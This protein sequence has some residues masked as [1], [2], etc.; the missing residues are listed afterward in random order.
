MRRPRSLHGPGSCGRAAVILCSVA[1]DPSPPAMLNRRSL[2]GLTVR[3]AH[4]DLVEVQP[5]DL[6]PGTP[7]TIA[8]EHER[9]PQPHDAIEVATS[10]APVAYLDSSALVKLIAREPE[11][12][13]LRQELVRRPRRVSS[14]LA[15]IEVTRTAR[16]L[17]PG[18]RATGAPPARRLAAAGDRPDR[19]DRHA[20]RRHDAALARRDP[21]CRRRQHQRRHRSAHHLRGA[22]DHRR[23]SARPTGALADV[24]GGATHARPLTHHTAPGRPLAHPIGPRHGYRRGGWADRADARSQLVPSCLRCRTGG[25]ARIRG[26]EEPAGSG[27]P[28]SLAAPFRPTRQRAGEPSGARGLLLCQEAKVSACALGRRPLRH[29]DCARVA[30]ARARERER[31]S[32]TLVIGGH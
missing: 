28:V 15:A 17:G 10:S 3:D 11:T 20:N 16:R 30:I 12:S 8:L 6:G 13:A 27:A 25:D 1:T 31:L 23:P 4:G 32:S 7:A 21:P 26:K 9:G 22:H 5:L 2:A 14:L 24:T 19:P 18:G 29:S